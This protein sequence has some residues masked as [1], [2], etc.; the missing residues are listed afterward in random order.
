MAEQMYSVQ[1]VL[2]IFGLDMS[3]QGLINA[4]NTGLI[5]PAKRRGSQRVWDLQDL[6]KIG[7]RY[8]YLKKPKEPV[9]AAIF[10]TKGGVLKSTIALNLGRTAGL[11][12]IRTCIVGLDM[13]C[14]ITNALGFQVDLEEA[15][16]LEEALE[17]LSA[18]YGLA[19]LGKKGIKVE[20]LLQTTDIP[21]LSLIP[22]T[23]DLV[24]L[25]RE[26]SRKNMRDFWLRD[27]IV[28]PL[29]QHFDLI[30]L[31]CSPN[32]N[33]LISN[34]LM[35]CDVLISPLE[36]KIN[37]FN[38]Y[39]A[40]KAYL[41]NFKAETKKSFEHIFIPTKYASTRKLSS[42]IR[43]WYLQNVPGCVG[44]V[45]R[46]SAAGEDS[47]AA[48]VSLPEYSP[49]TLAADEMRETLIEVWGRI[50]EAQNNKHRGE[51]KKASSKSRKST[52]KEAYRGVEA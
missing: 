24:M 16:S 42:E 8:G 14:D 52:S 35:A 9:V 6:P 45:I 46:E 17:L 23:S 21:T 2:Q 32:W 36:C 31:D 41:D 12:N 39:M 3:R 18:T 30:I 15:R 44:N 29:K 22:E 27:H 37:N 51:E 48:K 1:K 49:N 25:E 33:L 13:Q 38:N 26:I 50:L 34:A 11:H 40:F 4:E 10:T 47:M 28:E 43:S 5:P 19:D 7:E 20:S